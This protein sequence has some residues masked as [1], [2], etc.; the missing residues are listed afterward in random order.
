MHSGRAGCEGVL[1]QRLRLQPPNGLELYRL[2]AYCNARCRSQRRAQRIA[3][4]DAERVAECVTE[5]VAN[6][7]ADG[8][9]HV[10]E[11]DADGRAN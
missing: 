5:R 4:R 7:R 3:K 2:R 8:S 6:W 1:Q 9:K 11:W 10:A